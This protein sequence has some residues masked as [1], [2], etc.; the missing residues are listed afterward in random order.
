MPYDPAV[1]WWNSDPLAWR[2]HRRRVERWE[3]DGNWRAVADAAET[4]LVLTNDP[5]TWTW[6]RERGARTVPIYSPAVRF[7]FGGNLDLPASVARLR[8][9]GFRFIVVSRPDVAARAQLERMA[10]FRSLTQVRPTASLPLGDVYDLYAAELQ[11]STP[12]APTPAPSPQ[13]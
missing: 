4:R 13:R 7:L 10:F 3:A 2:E 8:E 1:K 11:R 6:L 5:F 9:Q 12:P